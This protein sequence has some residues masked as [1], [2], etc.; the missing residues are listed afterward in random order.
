LLLEICAAGA[1]DCGEA[2]GLGR[3]G[4]LGLRNR[5]MPAIHAK[6]AKLAIVFMR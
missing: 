1:E 2:A 3:R 4:V 6:T 5:G